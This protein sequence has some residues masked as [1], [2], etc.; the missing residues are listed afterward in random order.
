MRAV[1]NGRLQDIA[2]AAMGRCRSIVNHKSSQ[3]IVKSLLP[4]TF[5]LVRPLRGYCRL[6]AFEF[7]A[8]S[9][10]GSR[11]A[12]ARH[13][14]AI[15]ECKWGNIRTNKHIETASRCHSKGAAHA[16]QVTH[17]PWAASASECTKAAFFA[18]LPGYCGQIPTDW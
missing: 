1:L 12:P 13:K 14:V 4:P 8:F 18:K 5:H 11:P 6:A 9:M 7:R 3:P 16:C 2:K 10:A 15:L 17:Q